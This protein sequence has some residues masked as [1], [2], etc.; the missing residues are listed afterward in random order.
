MLCFNLWVNRLSAEFKARHP[1]GELVVGGILEGE[2]LDEGGT[3]FL[4]MHG[5]S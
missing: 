1:L 2:S 5:G 3:L 4:A